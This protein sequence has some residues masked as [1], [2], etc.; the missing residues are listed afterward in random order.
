MV[1]RIVAVLLDDHL[2]GVAVVHLGVALFAV[3][4]EVLIDAAAAKH[5]AGAA[6]VDRHF[7]RQDADAGRAL[8]EDRV[9]RQQGVILVD[10]RLEVVEERLALLQP[11]A[12]QI[13]VAP[14][15]VM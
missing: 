7:R 14:P 6:V 15:M 2:E 5:R 12:R 9:G 3:A 4:A 1:A 8:D 11:A 10:E 13:G